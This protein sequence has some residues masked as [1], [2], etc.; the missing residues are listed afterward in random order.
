MA[1]EPQSE[2]QLPDLPGY[3]VESVLGRGGFGVVL[4][5]TA[6]DGR[7][8][9]L[10]I[11][12]PG[13]PLAATQLKREETTLR[14]IGAPV[15]PEVL[16]SAPLANDSRYL[17]IERIDGI[18][19]AAR[20][21]EL[22]GPMPRREFT[23]RA[24]ALC[25]AIGAVHA[26]GYVHL[27]LK[28]ENILLTSQGV[29]LIDFGIAL[30]I[31]E[32]PASPG[33]F[34][35][36]YQYASPEQCEERVDLDIRADVYSTGVL[37]FE[38]L[39]GQP[40]FS[41]DPQQLRAAH[42]ALRPPHP[43]QFSSARSAVDDVVLRSLAKDRAKRPSNIAELKNALLIALQRES[44]ARVGPQTEAAP[45][46]SRVESRLVGLVLFT[47]RAGAAS[48]QTAVRSLGGELGWSSRGRYAAVFLSDAGANPARRAYR[49]AQ[50][51]L[52]QRIVVRAVLDV[53]V[54]N[55][56]RRGDQI[57]Y[58]A[59]ELGHQ[60]RYAKDVDP[61]GLLATSAAAEAITEISWEPLPA[62]PGYLVAR[63]GLPDRLATATIVQLG[64]GQL[65]GRERVL[66]ELLSI[67]Q[68]VVHA[69][70]AVVTVIADAGF[71]KTHLA[72]TLIE[73]LRA[74]LASA[75]LLELRAREP[76]P[77]D[78]DETLRAILWRALG[79]QPG[80]SEESTRA[81][82]MG[83]LGDAGME[84]WPATALTLRLI[85]PD[86]TR[87]RGLAAAP[88]VL[89]A[90]SMRAAGEVLRVRAKRR[91]LCVVLDDAQFA[92]D[93][94]L[95]ALEYASLK[96][97]GAPLFICAFGRPGFA[98]SRRDFG[99][100]SGFRRVHELG[101]L[102]PARSA[103]LCRRLLSPAENV[104]QAAVEALV[105]RTHGVPLLLVELI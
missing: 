50:E 71:G 42:A 72:A 87:V 39:T 26:A 12:T 47:T 52:D 86:A 46:A 6:R 48:V 101:A 45:R 105:A 94:A 90:M 70:P 44:P 60:D 104:P 43:S 102:E 31:G 3:T 82:F 99:E 78:P 19:L 53:G 56:T 29:R 93:T 2:L 76:V 36:T 64:A 41:G 7:K 10:K 100:R 25:D 37:L 27:D 57:R 84:L 67:A 21:R 68:S 62:R 98:R 103:E 23:A 13:D 54:T 89:R 96:E 1:E 35:G 75:E 8:V 61:I 77:G 80:A 79:L 33:S 40:P 49:A 58:L 28:P 65:V 73:Q 66:R 9:A 91:L 51:L 83:T 97:G 85:P 88:G 34:A 92:D 81:Q 15:A 22:H 16:D 59:P 14:A 24:I 11:A 5:A 17:S 95:D 38:M 18:S 74:Q 30:R 55:I 69:G 20:L 63:R 32:R 4:A